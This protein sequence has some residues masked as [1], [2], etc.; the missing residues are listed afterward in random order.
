MSDLIERYLA[1][2]SRELPAAQRADIIAELRDELM[3]RLE[4]EEDRLGRPMTTAELEAALRDFGNP[5]VVAGRFRRTQHL[6]GPQMFPFWWQAIKVTLTVMAA[7]YVV[8]ILL[9]IVAGRH[10]GP[11]APSPVLV[12]G[13]AFGLITLLFALAERF[14][15]PEALARRWRPR[16]LPPAK[17][18]TKGRF[19]VLVEMGMT[20]VA[21]AWWTGLIH[22][23]N[24]A[25][26]SDL[27]VDL[28]PVWAAWFW[29]I[30]TYMVFELV[31]HAHA[32]LRPAQVWLNGGLAIGRNLT[33]AAILFHVRQAG[34][35]VELS[36]SRIAPDTLETMQVN[37][38][39]GFHIG[40]GVA[41][42]VFVALAGVE[43]WRLSQFVRLR[44]APS[45]V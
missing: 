24:V 18:R 27:R 22:F 11:D 20:L 8:L 37:F 30:L 17:G 43:V 25:P 32:L 5:L 40:I 38:D 10:A 7:V 33:G 39:R 41:I 21:M 14:G 42:V 45:P 44:T 13:F 6:I 28:A 4:A 1:A 12:M 34:H 36:S 31:V 23:Q 19:E 26:S 9:A 3:S 16:R 35:Y 2:I 29:P 15:N